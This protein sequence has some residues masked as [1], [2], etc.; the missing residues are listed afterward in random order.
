[1]TC[2]PIRSIFLPV[3]VA[4]V[5]LAPGFVSAQPRPS[6]SQS[7]E[8]W[9]A[10]VEKL[11]PNEPAGFTDTLANDLAKATEAIDHWGAQV[12][13]YQDARTA[14]SV[15]GTTRQL[16][17]SKQRIDSVLDA[18]FALRGKF[19]EPDS[20]KL[21][22]QRIRNYLRTTSRLIDLSGRLRYLL[23]DALNL[24]SSRFATTLISRMQ[25]VDLMLEYRSSIGATA[26]IGFLFD[27]PSA[28]R[29]QAPTTSDAL[30][31]KLLQ[32]VAASGQMS[33]LPQVVRFIDQPN[34]PAPL[35]ILA[36]ET[37]REVGLPQEPRADTPADLPEPVILASELQAYLAEIDVGKLTAD[38]RQRHSELMNWLAKI[39][40]EGASESGYRLGSFDVQPGDW[41][42]MRNPSPYN[43]FTDLS[44]GLFTHVGVVTLEKGA[45]GIRRMVVVDIPEHGNKMPA[46]NVEIFVQRTLHY[47]FL[48]HPD[49][50]V[51]RAM[52]E[53]ARSIIGNETEF[54]LNFRTERVTALR[55]QPLAGQKIRT[56]CAGVLLLCALQSTAPREQF[57]PLPE[58][59]ASGHTAENL[60]RMGMT[61]GD[62]FISPTGALFSPHL[63]LVGRREPMYDPR[64]EV[65]EAVFDHFANQMMD[66][67]LKPA[68]AL[69]DALRL[70]LAE[71]S[72]KNPTLAE[73]L[74]K[75]AGIGADDLVA[76]AKAAAV[77][78]TLDEVAFGTSRKY[79][80]A[81]EALRSASAPANAAAT[82]ATYLARHADLSQ[83]LQQGRITPRQLRLAL[84][85]YYIQEGQREIDRRFFT[86]K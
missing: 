30:K 62:D 63:T 25:L 40:K 41:L 55:A 64:R 67:E 59:A 74:A 18:S 83:A 38:Q 78:E 76:A 15:T 69:F 52:A 20:E 24:V 85:K 16:L 33:L 68:T 22:R 47:T 61:F 8:A 43:L 5:L 17:E 65:E 26:T 53:A 48:R 86:G 21:D 51:A 19:A 23:S 32:L 2:P 54:D 29:I 4:L 82:N 81:R 72:Q 56:Y 75:A 7:L 39:A 49:Q 36:A 12:A 84:V 79:G 28:S 57:F 6:A 60:H 46:T 1:M 50:A 27:E 66:Q 35:V 70:K 80:E 71:A 45:D 9:I 10:Y 44:P 73:A 14:E 31:A 11:L 77:I 37:I 3:A 42:L 58:F 13:S 34:L